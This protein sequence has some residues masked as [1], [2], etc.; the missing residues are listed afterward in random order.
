MLQVHSG[1]HCRCSG[2]LYKSSASHSK[3]CM[4]RSNFNQLTVCNDLIIMFFVCLFEAKVAGSSKSHFFLL[5]K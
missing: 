2:K 1:I 4:A 5:N 3:K